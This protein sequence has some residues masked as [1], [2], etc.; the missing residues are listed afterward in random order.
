MPRP[1]S[2]KPDVLFE[3]NH[4]LVVNKPAG[5]LVQGDATG[6]EP[7][8]EYY[9]EY[10]KNKY[11]KPGAVFLGVIHRLDRPVS[12]A[13]AFARTSKALERMNKQFR[14]K[15]V[16]KVYWAQ[17]KRRPKAEEGT[18]T[19][20]LLKDRTKNRTHAYQSAKKGAQESTLTYRLIGQTNGFYLLEVKPATGRP[21]QIRTQLAAMGCPIVGDVKYGYPHANKDGSICLH[22]KL[23]SFTHPVKKEQTYISAPLPRSEQ[24]SRFE[25]FKE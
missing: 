7:L 23:L 19:N 12:G 13:L 9:K 25:G 14:D 3:D 10:I 16:N 6:D 17:V 22:S 18:L 5:F 1:K 8:A 4:L 2:F 15:E 11:N 20:W 24:W 21:H